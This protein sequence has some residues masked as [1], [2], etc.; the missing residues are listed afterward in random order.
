MALMLDN[1]GMG[2]LTEGENTLM[3]FMGMVAQEGKCVRGYSNSAY[4]YKNTGDSEFCLTAKP[5][6]KSGNYQA[7][8]LHSHAA[9]QCVWELK[10]TGIDMTPEED[11]ILEHIGMFSGLN[12]EG[13]I[14][15]HVINADV[16]PSYASGRRITLQVVGFP[17]EINYF[18]DESAYE[19][20]VP[21][22]E[23][24]KQWL[25]SVGSLLPL[26]FLNNHMV[27]PEKKEQKSEA[28]VSDRFVHFCGTVKALYHGIFRFANESYNAY[29]R[30]MIDTPFGELELAHTYEQVEKKQR[31]DLRVG[32]VVEGTCILSGD[33]AILKYE[34]GAVYDLENDLS[35]LQYAFSEGKSDKLI[36]LLKDTSVYVSE[37][38]RKSLVGAGQILD[39]LRTV[40]ADLRKG[41]RHHAYPAVITEAN[42]EDLAYPVSTPCLVLAYDDEPD[43]SA[44]AFIK[45]DADGKIDRIDISTDSRY[46]FKVNVPTDSDE[47][48]DPS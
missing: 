41:S 4:F 47:E 48:E 5:N 19:D 30:C 14:P 21:K 33:A 7:C 27:T 45:A 25:T 16:L 42:G 17:L 37:D 44:I 12:D 36:S 32:S 2:M 24:G 18:K 34:N 28:Q 26:A 46:R 35:V 9:N 8:N 31:N 11:D 43:F 40:A 13:L 38:S 6:T 3:N 10:H 1:L 15:I 20:S 29:I 39:H 22:D 23:N